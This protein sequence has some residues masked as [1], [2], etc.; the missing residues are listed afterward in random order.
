MIQLITHTDSCKLLARADSHFKFGTLQ[1]IDKGKVGHLQALLHIA[2]VLLP[3]VMRDQAAAT[4][5][6]VTPRWH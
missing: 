5:R 3:V 2:N 6:Y 4:R 1:P